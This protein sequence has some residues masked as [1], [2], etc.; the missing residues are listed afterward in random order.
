MAYWWVNQ[1]STYL[2][3]LAGGFLWSPKTNQNGA[4]NQHYV[5][6]T[7]IKPGDLVFSFHNQEIRAL[8]V[9]T[10]VATTGTKP[11]FGNKGEHWSDTGWRVPV[12]YTYVTNPVKPKAFAELIGPL[13]PQKY[14]PLT[15]NFDGT[16]AYL[17]SISEKLGELLLTLTAA[18]I[19]DLPI[20][21]LDQLSFDPEEQEIINERTLLQTEKA[22]LVMA[23]R[24]QGIFRNRVHLIEQKCRV[25][26]VDAD[27]LLIASH[28]K[29]W[30][31]SDNDER[32]SGYNGLFLSPHVDKLFN[33]GYISFE[34]NGA[35]LVSPQLQK[36]VLEKWSIDPL[37]RYG[38]FNDEQAY[39]LEHHNT[40]QFKAS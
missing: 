4:R 18:L 39:F 37:K 17:F 35:M 20:I 25:T 23:R 9:A 34:K 40:V 10:G 16:Q 6:M 13:L 7:L 21:E 14:S 1:G 38:K 26:G 28:I 12:E 30:K 11:D 24:G 31:L 5:N 15:R 33:D 29:P 22:T 2:E 36:D 19:P 3:E 32:V 27:K 8:G